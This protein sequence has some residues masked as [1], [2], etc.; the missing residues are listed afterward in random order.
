MPVVSGLVL[1]ATSLTRIVPVKLP[2]ASDENNKPL[3][4]ESLNP[5]VNCIVPFTI[6]AVSVALGNV[7]GNSRPLPCVLAGSFE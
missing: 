2:E 7:T 3:V 6:S 1:G 5:E 4:S